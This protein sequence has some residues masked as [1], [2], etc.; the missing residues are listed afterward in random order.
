MADINRFSLMIDVDYYLSDE[1][2]IDVMK[3]AKMLSEPDATAA[4]IMH[5]TRRIVEHETDVK[6]NVNFI[7]YGLY[8][9]GV[10][11]FTKKNIASK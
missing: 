9:R 7:V 5:L 3:R 10:F 8:Q 1:M 2:V 4:E 11:E 6:A